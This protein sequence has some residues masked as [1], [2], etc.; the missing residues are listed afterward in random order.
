MSHPCRAALTPPPPLH[1]ATASSSQTGKT[2]AQILIRWSLQHGFVPLPKSAQAA[3]VAENANVFDFAL[4]AAQ[5]ARLDG[6]DRGR[7][8]AVSWGGSITEWKD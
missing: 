4:T 6:L 7:D 3:R 1:I 5:M 8:G 2:P